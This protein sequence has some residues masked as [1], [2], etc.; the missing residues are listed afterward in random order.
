MVTRVIVFFIGLVGVRWILVS[1]V[2]SVVIPRPERVW[3][4]SMMFSL[5]RTVTHAVGSKLP[6]RL[7]HKVLGAFAP[8]VLIMLPFVWSIGM[9]LAFALLYWGVGVGSWQMSLEFSGS[10]MT[11]LG[12]VP[13]PN[14]AARVLAV[15]EALFGLGIIALMISFLPAL[16]GTFSRREIAVGKLTTRAG[17]PPNPVTFLKRLHEI[18]RLHHIDE[19]WGEWEDWFVELS[20]THTSFPALVYFRSAKPDRSWLRAAETALDTAA[21]VRSLDM[22]GASGEADLLIRSGSRALRNIADFYRIEPELEV[23]DYAKLSVD[24]SQFDAVI[25]T[26][27]SAGVLGWSIPPDAWEKFA[28]WRINY[29]RAIVGLEHLV[30]DLPGFWEADPDLMDGLRG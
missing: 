30:E 29:D 2:R 7:K 11:T 19:S 3:L 1:I 24:Q 26:L 4:T 20:E 6:P 5:S 22:P 17:A 23:A 25:E 12:F 14:A 16:Y 13:A 21:L 27:V 28:G 18:D 9:I 15:L 10:S 8:T